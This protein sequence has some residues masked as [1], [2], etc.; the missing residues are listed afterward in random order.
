MTLHDIEPEK[1]IYQ[2]TDWQKSVMIWWNEIRNVSAR[3][4]IMPN[5]P[6]RLNELGYFFALLYTQAHNQDL[7]PDEFYDSTLGDFADYARERTID[8]SHFNEDWV[9]IDY[10]N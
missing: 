2:I 7:N 1:Q 6:S 9:D 10:G 4:L 3:F 5:R 8:L